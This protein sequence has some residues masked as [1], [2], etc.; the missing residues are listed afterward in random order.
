LYLLPS[1]LQPFNEAHPETK[2]EIV[3]G[4]SEHLLR[5]LTNGAIDIGLIGDVPDE[6]TLERHLIFSD[7]LVLILSPDHRLHSVKEI[8][9]DDLANEF[10]IVQSTRSKL[11]QRLAQAFADVGRS[12]SLGVENIAVEAI[13]R[14]VIDKLGVGFVPAICVQEEIKQGKLISR[15]VKGVRDDWDVWIVRR[16]DHKNSLTVR[17]FYG[18]CIRTSQSLN[19]AS[20]PRPR[21]RRKQKRSRSPSTRLKAMH[22]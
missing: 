2:T 20:Q 4:T 15:S 3:C 17:E 1:L 7:R 5:A 6:P 10:L 8:T 11:R 21:Q 16:R 9:V 12:L 13:K 14:M 22:C 18:T 19:V